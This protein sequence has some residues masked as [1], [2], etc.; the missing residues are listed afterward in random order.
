MEEEALND[1]HK[2]FIETG[3][4]GDVNKFK[5]LISSNKEAL[6]DAYKLFV[7]TGYKGDISK[8]STL[9]GISEK[10]NQVG[11]GSSTSKKTPSVSTSKVAPTTSLDGGKTQPVVGSEFSVGGNKT[12][13]KGIGLPAEKEANKEN[14]RLN[15]KWEVGTAKVT[16]KNMDEISAKSKE[17]DI[18]NAEKT[19]KVIKQGADEI[20]KEKES[21]GLMDFAVSGSAGAMSAVARLPE[22]I[23]DINQAGSRKLSDAFG[24]GHG[25]SDYNAKQVMEKLGI[26]NDVADELDKVVKSSNEKIEA[27]NAKNGGDVIG[28]LSN[29]N[30]LGAAKMIAGST[31]QSAPLMVAAMATGG[32]A[33]ALATIGAVSASMTYA[34]LQRENPEMDQDVK[35][36]S[37]VGSGLLE[38]YV[39]KFFSGASGAAARRI[40]VE[41]GAEAGA[42]IIA[43]G[44][45]GMAMEAIEK[46]PVVGLVGEVIEESSVELGNQLI[47][48]SNGTRK[49][50]DMR[51]IY[52]AGLTSTGMGG[53]NTV[54]VYGAKGYVKA[55]EYKKSREINKQISSLSNELS[56]PNLS[57]SDKR[58][59]ASRV[60]KLILE[61][62]KTIGD[63]LNKIKSLP[64]DVKTE[65]VDINGK[66]EGFRDK[67]IELED[68]FVMSPE[69]KDALIT[70]IKSN[71][72]ELTDRKLKII[73]GT[74]VQDDFNK[75]SDAEKIQRK[76]KASR[77]LLNEAQA[78]GEE[79]ASFDDAQITKKAIEDYGT[80]RK[81]KSDRESTNQE[82]PTGDKTTTEPAQPTAETEGGVRGV[83]E[84]VGKEVS[85][86]IETKVKTGLGVSE[87]YSDIKS[88]PEFMKPL[89]K[90]GAKGETTVNGET[91]QTQ[92]YSVIATA[93]D[94][95]DAYDSFYGKEE[96][97]TPSSKEVTTPTPKEVIIPEK[98]REDVDFYT[99]SH[100]EDLD[101]AKSSLEEEKAKGFL[102]RNRGVIK[103]LERNVKFHE[104]NLR[105][106][107]EDP[108]GYYE[109]FIDS[110]KIRHNDR[111]KQDKAFKKELIKEYGTTDFETYY[112]GWIRDTKNKIE[113]L[114]KANEVK[115]T[116]PKS[117]I[118]S[119]EVA[120]PTPQE[121]LPPA[122]EVKTEEVK[123]TPDVV[124]EPI[125]SEV[126]KVEAKPIESEVKPIEPTVAETKED[127]ARQTLVEKTKNAENELKDA[128]KNLSNLGAIYDPKIQAEKQVAMNKAIV[129]FVVNKIALGA[130]DVSTFIKDMATNGIELTKEGADFLFDKSQKS[131]KTQVNRLAGPT[132]KPTV[133]T[134]K[135]QVPDEKLNEAKTK[136][137]EAQSKLKETNEELK[138]AKAQ[139][140][141]V[142]NASLE[143]VK[144]VKNRAE[145]NSK[146]RFE[147]GGAIESFKG[148]GKITQAQ[149]AIISK[150][151]AGLDVEDLDAVEDFMNQVDDV[152]KRSDYYE[153]V[154][155]AKKDAKY[156]KTASNNKEKDNTIRAVAKELA[157]L[158]PSILDADKT[159]GVDSEG[160]ISI[161][162]HIEMLNKAS[163][164]LKQ[165]TKTTKEGGG[166]LIQRRAL[167]V[168]E[169]LDYIEKFKAFELKKAKEKYKDVFKK[170]PDNDLTSSEI[171]TKISEYNSLKTTYKRL[172]KASKGEM[173][174]KEIKSLNEEVNA[175]SAEDLSDFLFDE[176][177]VDSEG[178]FSERYKDEV[179]N[180]ILVNAT[181]NAGKTLLRNTH[182]LTGEPF[183]DEVI[184]IVNSSINSSKLDMTTKQML[185]LANKLENFAENGVVGGL[186][187]FMAKAKSAKNKSVLSKNGVEGFRFK[188]YFRKDIGAAMG[189]YL[190]SPRTL[191]DEIFRGKSKG[192][193]VWKASGMQEFENGTARGI[194]LAKNVL[195]KFE[196]VKNRVGEKFMDAD[197]VYERGMLAHVMR[198]VGPTKEARDKNFLKVKGWMEQSIDNLLN[199][200]DKV[201]VEKGEVY[202]KVF[203][204]ILKDSN[205]IS[206][207]VSKSEKFNV[208]AVGVY[209]EANNL[210]HEKTKFT[211]DAYYNEGMRKDEGYAF[212]VKYGV[213]D[214]PKSIDVT[215]SSVGNG[216]T[217]NLRQKA[218]SMNDDTRANKLND[219]YIDLDFDRIAHQEFEKVAIAN[220]ALPFA[221]QYKAFR[222][223]NGFKDLIK[224]KGTRDMFTSVVED[225]IVES[226]GV[227]TSKYDREVSGLSKFFAPARKAGTTAALVSL[228]API[229]QAVPMIPSTL[230]NA[231]RFDFSLATNKDYKAFLDR[232]GSSTANRGLG[233]LV[234]FDSAA[235]S[236]KANKKNWFG[237]LRQ[238]IGNKQD[239]SLRLAVG[240]TDSE[241]AKI[242][243]GSYYQQK[244]G[245]VK[246][247][248]THKMNQEAADYADSMV[249]SDQGP[250]DP[251]MIGK[252]FKAKGMEGEIL[253]SM[254]MFA[255]FKVNMASNISK[256]TVIAFSKHTNNQDRK[257]AL[258]GL[259]GSASQ[260]A[261]FGALSI[262][263]KLATDAIA[264]SFSGED[265]EKAKED[266]YA[267][268][269]REGE[270]DRVKLLKKHHKALEDKELQDIY[271]GLENRFAVDMLSPMP[272]TDQL[273][274][275]LM[276]D[277]SERYYSNVPKEYRPEIK[278]YSNTK[279]Y[280]GF[281]PSGVYIDKLYKTYDAVITS[282]TGMV[283]GKV[284][285]VQTLTAQESVFTN[286]IFPTVLVISAMSGLGLSD[287]NNLFMK[288]IK[289]TP[290]S[291]KGTR[292][293]YGK[294][295]D[296]V[297]TKVGKT[298]AKQTK[299]D[300][301]TSK[302]ERRN[303]DDFM[304]EE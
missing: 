292:L 45:K 234:T 82:K 299:E 222:D 29:Q 289:Q 260:A 217:P 158:D 138:D 243:W 94:L 101:I 13:F 84:E 259:A 283:K 268:L 12:G 77:E 274:T 85:D 60:D 104:D 117:T 50:L 3:Y 93:E 80:E 174:S 271:L 147:I 89:A 41:N 218:T 249:G 9:V 200:E 263:I 73:E 142:F 6:N 203:D 55:S 290:K 129:K 206:E 25:T 240:L 56:N 137:K 96:Q 186:G 231:G 254:L 121:A 208:D 88:V 282:Q 269:T 145:K 212:P 131:Y 76:D 83:Q 23:F 42:K 239:E 181:I 303:W 253:K 215:D 183:S 177:D 245:T 202:R 242:S 69:T 210:E 228:T 166:T 7:D 192:D 302:K 31:L 4:K 151:L 295:D 246:D 180:I 15:L 257:T 294:K 175:M 247:W 286:Y 107:N 288:S 63:G 110:S 154:N 43:K 111:V 62:K 57:D 224:D 24:I 159:L 233:S 160:N 207:V 149:A 128:W 146:V 75:L 91:K 267:E 20:K 78:K 236:L 98:H 173:T 70:E 252:A 134:R 244:V 109:D 196:E 184:D 123:G 51:Q 167:N 262:G 132:R 190:A 172:I 71:V 191:V 127:K 140:K 1:A 248:K 235:S 205:S 255:R 30:Y 227:S 79:K 250:S 26:T 19:N 17:L 280:T 14:R 61:N 116:T 161:D 232:S 136:T 37:A 74:Y 125:N 238:K 279:W 193:L 162:E 293:S 304:R 156:L 198:D 230:I 169:V 270:L 124:S 150:K 103:G 102:T 95:Q 176:K 241:I 141:S 59:L 35:L 113:D 44:F 220:R 2:L 256:N 92:R 33:A 53:V 197:N 291:L 182:P 122:P 195:D 58:I 34:D 213:I 189:K 144:Q 296:V 179:E 165:T 108:V 16:S 8:F 133:S 223:M 49:E 18:L 118:T 155:V 52:N 275:A 27:Y 119:K 99:S 66:L 54:A 36:A 229:K 72:K 28:A 187:A 10:K 64:N 298:I 225:Y 251:N 100:Q 258:R 287:V 211:K 188:R 5:S 106:I 164:G 139:L 265:E 278:T 86:I 152:F 199:S 301:E 272:I 120:T 226:Q 276:T 112:A 214:T 300:I 277:L 157:S 46:S 21:S 114:K 115:P 153:K 130:Y 67:V 143:A 284:D 135:T 87:S 273:I 185:D 204:K 168:N 90:P 22:L 266:R 194:K 105:M 148:K 39:G 261:T 47:A 32:G 281:G 201:E 171:N 40:L 285:D 126:P 48:M 170:E 163:E 81:Q 38:A 97:A 219:N 264:N 178:D 216:K 297:K 65:I 209:Q 237:K 11:S 221:F 68:N